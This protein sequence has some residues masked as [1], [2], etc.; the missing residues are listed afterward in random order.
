MRRLVLTIAVTLLA[1]APFPAVGW[2]AWQHGRE[3]GLW[4][5]VNLLVGMPCLLF[6]RI[7]FRGIRMPDWLEW[8]GA[9]VSALML[10][11]LVAGL[12]APPRM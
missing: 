12:L 8:M 5:A 2:V 10:T 4:L 9:Y 6:L 3:D 11:W 7:A 1:S